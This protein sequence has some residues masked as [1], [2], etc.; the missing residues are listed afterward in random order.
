VGGEAPVTPVSTLDSSSFNLSYK[1]CDNMAHSYSPPL[2]VFVLEVEHPPLLLPCVGASTSSSNHSS[3]CSMIGL[4][5]FTQH[6]VAMSI[7]SDE[8]ASVLGVLLIFFAHNLR[9]Q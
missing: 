1:P 6:E 9:L 3:T 2:N 4:S 5:K 7:A 8:M